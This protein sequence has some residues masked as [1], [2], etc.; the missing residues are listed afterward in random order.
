MIP[1][2]LAE[3]FRI[4]LSGCWTWQAAQTGKGYGGTWFRGKRYRAHRLLY[5]LLRGPIP[6]GMTIDHLCRNRLCVNPEHCEIVTMREN[7]LRGIGPSAQHAKKTH[8][9]R[10]HEYDLLNTR[11]GHHNAR[12]CRECE[13]TRD[14]GR[15]R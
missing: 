13:K 1:Q 5:E 10:G 6:A 12:H 11:I 4:D 7:T 15:K 8:C 9:P 3:K 2:R 14:A